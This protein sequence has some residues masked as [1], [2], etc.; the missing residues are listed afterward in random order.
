MKPNDN[1]KTNGRQQTATEDE[2]AP[3]DAAL[4]HIGSAKDLMWQ[5]VTGLGEAL[6]SLKQVKADQK[7]TDKEIRQVRS[8]IRSLQKVEF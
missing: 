5:A 7:T 2:P 4:N 8:T 6:A 1:D 3:L